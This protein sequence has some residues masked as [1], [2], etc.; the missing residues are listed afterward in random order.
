MENIMR[1]KLT[2]CALIAT[3]AVT[4]CANMNDTQKKTATGAGVGAAAGAVLG[5]VTGPGGWGRAAAGAALGGLIGGGAGYLWGNHMEKQKQEMQTATQGTGVQVVQTPD[6]Q[7]KVSIPSDVSFATNSA[8]ISPQ[9]KTILRD[10]A[11]TLK[12]NPSTSIT[13]IGYTDNTGSDAINQPLS[14]ERAMS[15]R[16]Y[17]V[18]QGVAA[19]RF[20]VE[21]KGSSDPIASNLTAAGRA[22]NR[23]VEIYIGERAK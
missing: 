5:A 20:T 9:F 21:G 16:N 12:N 10:L 13:V 15:V 23:R 3:L 7:I 2:A 8:T 22:E 19:D 17:L 18:S 11:T 14:R 1:T 4:G 6:N